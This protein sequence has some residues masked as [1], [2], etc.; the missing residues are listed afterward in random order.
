MISSCISIFF[1]F[2]LY[3]WYNYKFG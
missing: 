1:K 2:K 3:P